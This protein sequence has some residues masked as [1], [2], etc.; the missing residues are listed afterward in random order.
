[1][2]TCPT[3]ETIWACAAGHLSEDEQTT[4]AGHVRKCPSCARLFS[5]YA[6]I[7]SAC[8]ALESPDGHTVHLRPFAVLNDLHI[9]RNC[10][11]LELS[12]DDLSW[13]KGAV[14]YEIVMPV[15]EAGEYAVSLGDERAS[16]R[17]AE[18][19]FVFSG[20]LA[21]AGVTSPSE[22]HSQPNGLFSLN[23][24]EPYEDISSGSRI[25]ARLRI[26]FRFELPGS[27]GLT[28]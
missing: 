22:V 26:K 17:L 15:H 25:P 27:T 7:R 2:S 10:V 4:V 13:G 5:A 6:Q 19:D 14:G 9:Y 12:A 20:K 23:K 8:E 3:D 18:E 21:A 24:L 11:P 16:I 28:D 1:M